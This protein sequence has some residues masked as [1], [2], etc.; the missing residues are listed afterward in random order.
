[1]L[2]SGGK[3]SEKQKK[4][5]WRS[6]CTSSRA[7]SLVVV[8]AGCC[9]GDGGAGSHIRSLKKNVSKWKKSEQKK[10]TWRSRCASSQALSLVVVVVVVIVAGCYDGDGGAGSRI[11]SSEKRMLVSEKKSEKQKKNTWRSR[12]AS[13]RALSLVVVIVVAWCYDVDGGDKP[14]VSSPILRCCGRLSWVDYCDAARQTM[15]KIK[16]RDFKLKWTWTFEVEQLL[17]LRPVT[18]HIN[19]SPLGNF[20]F[21]FRCFLLLTTHMK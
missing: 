20:L 14:W 9:D 5:T 6:R 15:T 11:R 17:Q 3:K 19:V 7:P 21:F 4:N 2:V 8:V 12:C 10:N 1:M 16:S 13:S 18:V